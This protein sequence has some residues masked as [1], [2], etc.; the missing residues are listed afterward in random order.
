MDETEK[1]DCQQCEAELLSEAEELRRLND[2]SSRLWRTASLHA[3]LEEML[4]TTIELLSASF[5]NVQLI[6][7]STGKLRIASQQGFKP[8]FLEFFREVSVDDGSACGQ[9]LQLG[10]RVIIT[11]VNQDPL[12]APYVSIARKA[13]FRAVQ[14]T[15]LL[16]RNGDV[17]D[18]FNSFPSRPSTH[19]DGVRAP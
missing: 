2:A 10:Q 17:R 15:P 8:D 13:G 5:G 12:F 14:S 3:G 9:A 1:S 19:R 6:D 4:V 7:Q 16:G 11:D 18:D